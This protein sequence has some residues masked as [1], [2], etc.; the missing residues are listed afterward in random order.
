LLHI[1]TAHVSDDIVQVLVGDTGTGLTQEASERLFES[2]YTTKPGGLGLGL[3]VCRSIIQSHG[4]RLWVESTREGG[5]EFQF[6]LPIEG[7]SPE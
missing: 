4:G 7:G 5:T 6:T 2:F 3:A 1:G